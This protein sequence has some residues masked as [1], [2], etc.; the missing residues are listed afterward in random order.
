M[1]LPFNITQEA[2]ELLVSSP[3]SILVDRVDRCDTIGH[4]RTIW[5]II[6]SCL[7]T[8]FACIWV[9]IHPNVPQPI[10]SC[11][12]QPL[13]L[14]DMFRGPGEKLGIA[15]LALLAPEFIF[16]W[17]SRQWL[18]A[19]S[20]AKECQ[21]AAEGEYAKEGRRLQ[22]AAKKDFL[23]AQQHLIV[24]QERAE[25][26]YLNAILDNDR[27]LA[28]RVRLEDS[29]RPRVSEPKS[30][31]MAGATPAIAKSAKAPSNQL[32]VF[33]LRKSRSYLHF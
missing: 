14:V 10:A 1:F 31:G 26:E 2:A 33:S 20:I 24:A 12:N 25:F 9:A 11:D 32:L 7:V 13:K 27:T 28:Q 3:S 21:E 4:C 30:E 5:N 16:V 29:L 18:R 22:D 19:R 8:I 15:L 6:W 23:I 17:A